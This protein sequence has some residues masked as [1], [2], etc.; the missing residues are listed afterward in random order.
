MAVGGVGHRH[1]SSS[2]VWGKKCSY[3][4]GEQCCCFFTYSSSS[5]S[6]IGTTAHC[7]LWPV[8]KCPSIFSYLPPTLSIFSLP[9]L[10]NL[11]LLPLSIFTWVFLF[12]SS[13][14]VI[15]WNSFWASYPPPAW[16]IQLILCPFIHFT[17]VSPFLMSSSSR[18]VRLFH[19]P[20]S[21]LAPYIL[22]NIFLSKISRAG[23]SFFFNVHVPLHT[24][25]PVFSCTYTYLLTYLL[26]G[27]ESF[28]RS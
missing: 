22:L 21:Y 10:E 24:T 11:F 12:F 3:A 19:S 8:E 17:I 13:L 4:T 2:N 27:A 18:F 25:L 26:H 20:F 1:K 7:G 5:S 28:L 14:P 16:R 6:S 9:T 15:E 23:S